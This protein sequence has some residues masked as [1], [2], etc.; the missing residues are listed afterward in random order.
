MPT[1]IDSYK[2]DYNSPN[3]FGALGVGMKA[4]GGVGMKAAGSAVPSV[5][6]NPLA[7]VPGAKVPNPADPP[8]P[9]KPAPVAYTPFKMRSGNATPFK[10]MGSS[11][12]KFFGQFMKAAKSMTGMKDKAAS[13]AQSAQGSPSVDEPIT[14]A[15]APH[16]DEA[17]TGGGGGD[18]SLMEQEQ[19]NVGGFGAKMAAA[20]GMGGG[21]KNPWLFGSNKPQPGQG[22]AG[23][24]IGAFS[25][26]R[27]KE[28][29]ERTGASPSGI[30]I[31]EFNYIGDTN[32]YS[33]AMAQD[34]LDINPDVVSL[35]S[36]GYYKVNYNDIDVD[37]HLIN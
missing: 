17:H 9:E 12:T 33:G 31:Y 25:D 19:Q 21:M 4:L 26:A 20:G 23:S 15:V 8:K 3:N 27:L 22:F 29:I 14:P 32:R 37:M 13:L 30:P 24:A 10:L 34:L 2:I 16:G 7:E 5:D 35:D 28:K 6:P 1:D 11:P 18:G 36:S